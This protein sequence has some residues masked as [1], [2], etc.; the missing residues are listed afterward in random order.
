MTAPRL[1]EI[2][3]KR[4]AALVKSVL[5]AAHPVG[6]VYCSVDATSPADLFGGTWESI[7]AGRVLQGADDSHSGGATIEAGLPNITGEINDIDT[8]GIGPCAVRVATGAFAST[9]KNKNP[10]YI[11]TPGV[12]D[13][14]PE[15]PRGFTFD[16]SRS[17]AV[18]GRSDTVQPPAYIVYMWRRTA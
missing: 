15:D 5:L 4:E 3:K 9:E 10:Q 7:A 16:A 18:Y 12:D 14:H 8:W 17:S 1:I 13:T 6:S 11:K 2:F